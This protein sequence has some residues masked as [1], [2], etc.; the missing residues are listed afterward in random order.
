[1][2]DLISEYIVA[3]LGVMLSVILCIGTLILISRWLKML[4]Q[5]TESKIDEIFDQEEDDD[6][7]HSN[8]P[9]DSGV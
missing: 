4:S 2:F 1:M 6:E 7:D 5:A 3:T 8:P 9:P